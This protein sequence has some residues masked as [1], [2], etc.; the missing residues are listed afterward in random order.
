VAHL[1]RAVE[2]CDLVDPDRCLA[3]G[4]ARVEVGMPVVV[5]VHRDRDSV[6]AADR[7][8]SAMVARPPVAIG[9]AQN[10]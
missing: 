1:E 10:P 6:E 8:H 4:V 9:P 5:E 7:R 2:D 3:V